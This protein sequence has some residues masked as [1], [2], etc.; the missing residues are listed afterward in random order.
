MVQDIQNRSLNN[1]L[2]L[3]GSSHGQE[4]SYI[5]MT[6]LKRRKL[7]G[8]LPDGDYEI[9]PLHKLRSDTLDW[10]PNAFSSDSA[11]LTEDSLDAVIKKECDAMVLLVVRQNLLAVGRYSFWYRTKSRHGLF[12][13]FQSKN[14]FH[15]PVTSSE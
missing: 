5:A 12:C 13:L 10:M 6:P 11:A 15:S 7:S 9:S 1:D 4:G 14:F 3:V 2:R 8:V